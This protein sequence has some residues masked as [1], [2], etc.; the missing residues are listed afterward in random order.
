MDDYMGKLVKLLPLDGW[1][2]KR[3][4]TKLIFKNLYFICIFFVYP[5]F[6]YFT[7][8]YASCYRATSED[9]LNKEIW[10]NVPESKRKDRFI[11]KMIISSQYKFYFAI[12]NTM[13]EDNMT[14]KFFQ[15]I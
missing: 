12:E 15:G 14:E 9:E 6:L 13:I 11:K 8:G 3:L 7:I 1:L 5:F 4:F 10:K 2:L